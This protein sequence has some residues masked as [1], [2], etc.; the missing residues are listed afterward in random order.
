MLE[1][2]TETTRI[3]KG[4]K[5]VKP[6]TKGRFISK[7]FLREDSL[8]LRGHYV[9]SG[10]LEYSKILFRPKN[11]FLLRTLDLVA[12]QASMKAKFVEERIAKDSGR[13]TAPRCAK[14]RKTAQLMTGN[15]FQAQCANAHFQ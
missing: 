15:F 13:G 5:K 2:W 12:E 10:S 9:L 6:V 7:M 1:M 11:L 8:I 4:K 3:G 14:K